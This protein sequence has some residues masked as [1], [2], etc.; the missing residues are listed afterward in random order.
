MEGKITMGIPAAA[1][2]H[3]LFQTLET[4]DSALAAEVVHE[5]FHNREAAVSPPACRIAGPAGVLASS[6]WM[7]YAFTDLRL[8]IDEVL[9]DD[10]QVWVRLHM[11]GRHTGAFVRFKGEDVDQVVPPTGRE[12]DFEQI[13]V[14]DLHD[15][16]V[17]RHRAVRDDITMLGQLGFFP[18][19][20]VAAV[21]MLSWRIT[22]R[23][24]RAASEV[25]QRAAEAA[26]MLP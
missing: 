26:R 20:P 24:A 3:A 17:I 9:A 4:G 18:P 5:Q 15:G 19:G 2:G 13:H 21:S 7:R 14:L 11:K 10:S 6:A 23:A 8:P 16:K 1:L 25:T 12:I 22:G